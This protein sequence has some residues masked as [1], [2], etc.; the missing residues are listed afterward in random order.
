MS[1]K[2]Q[3]PEAADDA[4]RLPEPADRG[5]GHRLQPLVD[6]VPRHRGAPVLELLGFAALDPG[7]LAIKMT[8]YRA[9]SDAEAMRALV[10]YKRGRSLF[11]EAETTNALGVGANGVVTERHNG[12]SSRI[13]VNSGDG[14][15]GWVV[16]DSLSAGAP[17]ATR[18]VASVSAALPESGEPVE[19]TPTGAIRLGRQ[20]PLT[21]P[22]G[23][24][25]DAEEALTLA[26]RV[27]L[28]KAKK[29]N[30]SRVAAMRSRSAAV[31]PLSFSVEG[32][33]LRF[34]HAAITAFVNWP[35]TPAR[36]AAACSSRGYSKTVTR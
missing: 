4:R 6:L 30:V 33:T 3:P 26:K 25:L 36:S 27:R 20:H 15:V 28:T 16:L 12:A 35:R 14:V 17:L 8:L 31:D 10:L 22:H 29:L 19:L 1:K 32:S 13:A 11:G 24:E 7:V 5:H 2:P 34:R 9:G 21:D 23:F 18:R